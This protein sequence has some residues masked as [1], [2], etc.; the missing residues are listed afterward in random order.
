MFELKVQA[1]VS[2]QYYIVSRYYIF[3]TNTHT[4]SSIRCFKFIPILYYKNKVQIAT[5]LICNT[6]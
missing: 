5:L 3:Q 6:L 2:Q 4:G 1:L